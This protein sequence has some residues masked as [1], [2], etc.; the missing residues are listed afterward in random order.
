MKILFF[1]RWTG[2]HGGGTET[3]LLEL[4]GRFSRMGH[5]VTILTREGKMLR[6]PGEKIEVI[7]VSRNFRESDHSYEDFR[8]Y[9]HTALF[10]VKSLCR[11]IIL[12]LRGRRFDV[13]SVHFTTEGLVAM[14]FRFFSGTPFIF[15]LE[16]YTPQEAAIAK[17][18]D[19]RVAI[20]KFEAGVYQEKHGVDSRVIYIGIDRQRFARDRQARERMRSRFVLPDQLLVLT[21]CRLEP[22]KDLFTLIEAARLL[23]EK[24]RNL[25]FVIAGDGILKEALALRIREDNLGD[26][27]YQ[28]GFVS[29]SE[30]PAYYSAADMFLLPSKEEWFGI[31]FLE[32]MAA[33]LPIIAANVDACPEVVDGCGVFFEKGNA[34]DLA[35]KIALLAGDR[36]LRQKFALKAAARAEEFS[37]ERQIALYQEAYQNVLRR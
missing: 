12:H 26:L 7:R 22:R 11:L 35:Q 1:H 29:D 33:G 18:A 30:L 25:R 13:I 16:G 4:A 15:V 9:I 20:S 3:H 34:P 28:A 6:D 32:A 17:Y 27:I 8:V 23:R 37:W 36:E 19:Q 21:V 14:L 10:M 5:E 2:V 24:V 31:V